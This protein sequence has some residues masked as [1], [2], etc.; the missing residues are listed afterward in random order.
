[1]KLRYRYMGKI[2][3]AN[4]ELSKMDR[5]KKFMNQV[6]KEINVPKEN[7]RFL[8][9]GKIFDQKNEYVNQNQYLIH[10]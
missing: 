6:S 1:M 3:Q 5:T 8:F 9:K 10:T 4:L 7:L 2:A